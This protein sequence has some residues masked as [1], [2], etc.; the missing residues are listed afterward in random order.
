[1]PPL[2]LFLKS[3][4][5]LPSFGEVPQKVGGPLNMFPDEHLGKGHADALR[6]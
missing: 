3:L 5:R 4:L 2:R 1:M 6:N